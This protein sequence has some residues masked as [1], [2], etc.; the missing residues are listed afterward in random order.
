MGGDLPTLSKKG[1]TIA[2][3]DVHTGRLVQGT[4]HQG[5]RL[6]WQRKFSTNVRARPM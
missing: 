2:S 4:T 1:Q 6:P 3:V 5:H